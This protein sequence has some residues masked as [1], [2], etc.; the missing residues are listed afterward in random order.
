MWLRG[1]EGIDF[2]SESKL[3]KA[4]TAVFQEAM[5]ER[6]AIASAA[7]DRSMRIHQVFT[8]VKKT[9]TPKFTKAIKDN[10][11]LDVIKVSY[12]GTHGITGLFA[13]NLSMDNF[14]DVAEI[15]AMQTGQSTPP[16]T[17]RQS[18]IE[19]RDMHKQLNTKTG[20][21]T[22]NTYGKGRKIFCEL[23]MDAMY[24]FLLHD[25]IP[26]RIAPLPTAK[27][28]AAIYLH[29]IGHVL[30][31]VERSAHWYMTIERNTRH[32]DVLVKQGD[33]KENLKA[34]I[35]IGLPML[36]EMA[37]KNVIS[38]ESVNVITNAISTASY[39]DN[40][41]E[42]GITSATLT[43]IFMTINT[44]LLVCVHIWFN[45]I[46]GLHLG[47]LITGLMSEFTFMTDGGGKSSDTT[48]TAHNLYMQERLA[49]EF[50]SRHGAGGH[51]ASALNSMGVVFE[52]A[53]LLDGGVANTRLKK[54]SLF[55]GMIKLA[56]CV[57]K[58]AGVFAVEAPNYE[59]Q[60]N[61]VKRLIQNANAMFKN[62]LIRTDVLHMYLS[63]YAKLEK[64][65]EVAKGSRGDQARKI[66]Y[67]YL[68]QYAKPTTVMAM[69][70]TGRFTA[71]YEKQQNLVE[72]LINNKLYA[73][74]AKF[75]LRAQQS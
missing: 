3:F 27:E 75:K 64:E 51:L 25:F 4:L 36:N 1:F 41:D 35:E 52:A 70:L 31:V 38:K 15:V 67:D 61:R 16:K 12:T 63:D 65:L 22:S 32:L 57:M 55:T 21:L 56:V 37:K 17:L 42:D 30:T 58:W 46:V 40:I 60:Y 11:N 54:L 7:P 53:M 10:T 26:E 39:M 68:I 72:D 48:N 47:M 20:E 6:D 29:E 59:A 34:F 62:Q 2:Q 49:D 18:L 23:Y 9:F 69:L 74:S 66:I 13:V 45:T 71:D 19:M 44:I 28:L 50:V 33:R 24:A 73:L 8:Y 14:R 5:D 43:L